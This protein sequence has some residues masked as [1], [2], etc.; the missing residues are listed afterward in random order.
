MTSERMGVLNLRCECGQTRLLAGFEREL[1]G[2]AMEA[3]WV[4]ESGGWQCPSCRF[5]YEDSF[6][7]LANEGYRGYSELPAMRPEL[8]GLIDPGLVFDDE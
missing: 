5:T 8:V 1:L 3:G 7:R 4:A 2:R 6:E